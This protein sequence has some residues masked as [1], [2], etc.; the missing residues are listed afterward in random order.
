MRHEECSPTGDDRSPDCSGRSAQ[1]Q[2]LR[3]QTLPAF[4]NA[5]K[6]ARRLRMQF[7]TAKLPPSQSRDRQRRTAQS[8]CRSCRVTKRPTKTV[9]LLPPGRQAGRYRSLS[10]RQVNSV[11]IT[12]CA[13]RWRCQLAV[14]SRCY[15]GIC[16]RRRQ[17]D[18]RC[19]KSR[20]VPT[21]S[22]NCC[23]TSASTANCWTCTVGAV[24][25]SSADSCFYARDYFYTWNSSADTTDGK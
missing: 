7:W 6:L 21:C 5:N 9:S 2:T 10:R 22:E 12:V 1:L 13:G 8:F 15:T 3:W 16:S 20:R 11:E 17:L 4:D 18:Y 19:S 25:S 24:R 23:R 14:S